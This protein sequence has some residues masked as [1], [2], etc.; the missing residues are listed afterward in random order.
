[1]EAREREEI[2][3]C[4]CGCGQ[5]FPKFDDRKRPRR[6]ISGHNGKGIK[7]AERINLICDYCGG[8]YEQYK[9]KQIYKHHFCSIHCR[10]LWCGQVACKT[11]EHRKKLSEISILNGNKPPLHI[12]ENHWNWKGGISNPN[13]GKDFEYKK[14]H[15]SILR[16]YNYICQICGIRG[17]HLSAHHIKRWSEYP[18]LRYD[19]ENGLCLCYDCHMELHGLKKKTA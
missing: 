14:W 10:A 5:S 3:F 7:K 16:K 13:R 6:F 11:E 8:K 15:R 17:G 18:E 12:K 4:E 1:M 19:I 2:I 9:C